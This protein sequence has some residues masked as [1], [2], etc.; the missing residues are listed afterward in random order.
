MGCE[1]ILYKIILGIEIRVIIHDPV[2]I[3]RASLS[4]KEP[5]LALSWNFNKPRS[6]LEHAL[7][8]QSAPAAERWGLSRIRVIVTGSRVAIHLVLGFL[9]PVE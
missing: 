9:I 4:G 2:V 3:S 1:G 5:K 7:H 6:I 8:H